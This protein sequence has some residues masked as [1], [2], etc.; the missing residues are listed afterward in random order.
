VSFA[1]DDGYTSIARVPYRSG[2]PDRVEV[3][4]ALLVG[5]PVG[6]LLGARKVSPTAA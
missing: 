6:D 1:L 4:A 3:A 2:R 5:V